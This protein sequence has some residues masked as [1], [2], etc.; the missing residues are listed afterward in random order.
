MFEPNSKIAKTF[1]YFLNHY[2]K[3]IAFCILE[4]APVCNNLSER[5]LNCIIRHR[6][7]SLFFKTQIGANVA[8]IFTSILF[9]AK[10]NN[11]NSTHYLRDLFLYQALWKKNPHQWLPW[12]YLTTIEKIKNSTL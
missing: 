8:D 5:M 7:N 2:E 11:I 1:Q 3:F 4:N 12:N 9:T 6:R 10:A